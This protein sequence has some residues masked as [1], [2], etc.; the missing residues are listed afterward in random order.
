M[1]DVEAA[2]SAIKKVAERVAR[3]EAAKP[4]PSRRPMIRAQV[5]A[6]E[7]SFKPEE[8]EEI[9]SPMR[10]KAGALLTS[11]TDSTYDDTSDHELSWW[12]QVERT[13]FGVTHEPWS[14]RS[15]LAKLDSTR[16]HSTMSDSTRSDLVCACPR[17][18][19][20]LQE[21]E[22]KLRGSDQAGCLAC[23]DVRV[24]WDR[25]VRLGA[26]E[27]ELR[28]AIHDVKFTAFRAL[29]S[30][31]GR[32][33]GQQL[34]LALREEAS[35]AGM[36]GP[37]VLVP[38]PMPLARRLWRGIDHTMVLATGMA[39]ACKAAGLDVRVESPLRRRHRPSQVDVPPNE[40]GSNVAGSFAPDQ[41]WM[42]WQWVRGLMMGRLGGRLGGLVGGRL[43][44]GAA[45]ETIVMVDDVRTTGS[46]LAAACRAVRK[47]AMGEK[48]KQT[49]VQALVTESGLEVHKQGE[50]EPKLKDRARKKDMAKVSERIRVWVAVVA[51]AEIRDSR[52]K[53]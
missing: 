35:K 3:E 8:A 27:S 22:A 18:G 15:K 1:V 23:R 9:T 43:G 14:R 28:D 50:K 24:P 10:T 20:T 37:V 40:R 26:Y 51:V 17:C 30:D 31:L 44:E 48:P 45:A 6:P 33:L 36:V 34:I 52:G 21:A 19:C 29:G 53:S 5:V 47:M 39:Q 12:A 41:I 7:A 11:D 4:G 46:T 38:V 16:S 49:Q 25:C 13:W 32:S 42:V 2:D